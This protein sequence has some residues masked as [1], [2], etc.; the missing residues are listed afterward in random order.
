M[1]RNQDAAM[2]IQM[3]GIDHTRAPLDVRQEFAFT[4]KAIAEAYERLKG[5]QGI[6]GCV[7]VSTCNRMELWLSCCEEWNDDLIRMLCRIKHME[8]SAFQP[9]FIVRK[10]QEAVEHLFQLAGGLKSRILGE[11]QILS[12]VKEALTFA[13]ECYATDQVMEVLFRMAVTGG[14]RVKTLAPIRRADYSAAHEAIDALQRQGYSVKEKT[15][16]VIGNGEMGRMTA[17]AL[18][19]AGAQVTMT[20]RQYHSGQVRI[21]KGC[22]RINYGERYQYI[23]GCDLVVSATASPNCTI[24]REDLE[25]TDRRSGQIYIDLAVPRDIDPAIGELSGIRL[26][27]IDSFSGSAS[28]AAMEDQIRRADGIL[29]EKME[30]FYSWYEC[31]N[32]LPQVKEISGRASEDLVWRTRKTTGT[33]GLSGEDRQFL[34]AGTREAA[35]KVVEKLLFGLRDHLKPESFRE[36]LEALGQIYGQGED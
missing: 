9:Y 21:P 12:Q 18:M 8:P 11:D 28:S 16:L 3:I 33:M 17:M 24:S 31:R 29:R 34:E 32:L 2:N 35:A 23:P 6:L 26:F 15:C 5:K 20:V 19:E 7:I 10:N 13:R 36:C 25:K 22:R 4:Q 1:E 14:K 27:N 30:E